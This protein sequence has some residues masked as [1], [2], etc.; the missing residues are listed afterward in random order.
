MDS[1][2]LLTKLTALQLDVVPTSGR[3]VYKHLSGL[4]CLS[5]SVYALQWRH[6]PRPLPPQRQPPP[7]GSLLRRI[8]DLTLRLVPCEMGNFR[9]R[10]SER[11]SWAVQVI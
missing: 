2:S 9:L 7:F 4:S 3:L 5:E 11:M 10:N 8:A 1:L 6:S